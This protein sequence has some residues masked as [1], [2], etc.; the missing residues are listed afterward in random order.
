LTLYTSGYYQTEFTTSYQN[1]CLINTIS[2]FYN[3]VTTSDYC[4]AKFKDGYTQSGVFVKNH[5]HSDDWISS[6]ALYADF[7]DGFTIIQ[8][9]ALFNKY[10][11]YL[12][13]SK[14]HQILKK[15][16]VCDRFHAVFPIS[17]ITDI[18]KHKT[19]LKIL[20]TS[21]LKSKHL[22]P[23]CIDSCRF[24][25]ANKNTQVFYNPGKHIDNIVSKLYEKIPQTIPQPEPIIPKSY[26]KLMILK[27]EKAYKLGWFESY[28]NWLNL[29][30]ALHK[31][32]FDLSVWQK[33]CNSTND[34]KLAEYKWKGFRDGKLGMNYLRD[35]CKKIK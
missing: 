19:Y 23:S 35:I 27:L 17:T 26:H 9:Q 21:F 2:D 24:F 31:A 1:E 7:D 4:F 25:F 16:K 29:G 13:T 12:T 32:D 28:N 22:D 30:I 14:S 11:Y 34:I 6:D 33:F 3:I 20:H 10:E 18:Q 5:R 15:D 8:F